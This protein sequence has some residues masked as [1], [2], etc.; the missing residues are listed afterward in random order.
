MVMG[1]RKTVGMTSYYSKIPLKNSV[2]R[3]HIKFSCGIYTRLV[4]LILQ[5]DFFDWSPPWNHKFRRKNKV[6]NWS[7][8]KI[9]KSHK[10]PPKNCM[11]QKNRVLNW[12][13]LKIKFQ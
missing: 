2:L 6:P 11:F 12:S 3:L 9:T 8:L 4:Y 7:P 13:P 10:I 5:S 1:S